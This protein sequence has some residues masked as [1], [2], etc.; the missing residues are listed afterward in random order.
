[1]SETGPCRDLYH[2]KFRNS[3]LGFPL[4]VTAKID[5]WQKLTYAPRGN[6]K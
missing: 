1:M 4:K 3:V 2:E 5:E 6:C